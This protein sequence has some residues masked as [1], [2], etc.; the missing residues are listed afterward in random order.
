MPD[1][2]YD[3]DPIDQ[4]VALAYAQALFADWLSKNPARSP[5]A[6]PHLKFLELLQLG[7][8]VAQDLRYR[9]AGSLDGLR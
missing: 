4:Q 3:L 6:S 7:A 8:S 1:N 5:D 2:F 9:S